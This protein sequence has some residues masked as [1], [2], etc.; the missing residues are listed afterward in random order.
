MAAP[1]HGTPT[2]PGETDSEAPYEALTAADFSFFWR[3]RGED[4]L[5][6]EPSALEAAKQHV[7]AVW[8]QSISAL[9][10]YRCV[11]KLS[12]LSPRV[13]RHP[14]YAALLQRCAGRQC[15]VADVGCAF[16]QEARQ[17]VLDGV[18]P[19]S[20]L[21]VDV[22]PDYWL[23]GEALFGPS[24]AHGSLS[25][26]PT[27]FGDWAAPATELEAP[28]LASFDA[29]LCMFVLHVL[30]AQQQLA[31]LSR[32]RR[33]AKPGALLLG[34]CVGCLGTAGEWGITPD[35]SGVARWLHS[36]ESLR[37]QL[38]RAGWAVEGMDVQCRRRQAGDCGGGGASYAL[39]DGQG[40]MATLTFSAVAS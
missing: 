2:P 20:L 3:W 39:A 18:F 15:R 30:S 34:A 19:A 23:A 35:G 32:L 4:P 5:S 17:L 16:G 9:F 21:A 24:P 6:T 13:Q 14:A 26:A 29:A 27:S 31:L 10:R 28:H 33:C 36:A 37:E 38:V 40:L 25:A 7:A 1:R 8:R 22:T 12:F 11:A